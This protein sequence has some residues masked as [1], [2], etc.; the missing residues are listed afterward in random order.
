MARSIP[1]LQRQATRQELQLHQAQAESADTAVQSEPL[2]DKV[3][4]Y[5]DMAVLNLD[6]AVLNL[7]KAALN[8]DKAAPQ[9]LAIHTADPH[10]HRCLPAD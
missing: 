9:P 10:W 4:R 8:L 1:V 7:D 2:P 5:W 6:K 3:A